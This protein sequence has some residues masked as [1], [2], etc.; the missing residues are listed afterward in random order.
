LPNGT[1]WSL[2]LDRGDELQLYALDAEGTIKPL[3]VRD[4]KVTVGQTEG[5]L[6]A[7][8]SGAPRRIGILYHDWSPDGQWLWYATLKPSS[9]PANVAIDDAVVSQRNRR[10]APVRAIVELR[11]RSATGEDWLVA[12]RPSGDRLAFY[13]GGHVEW[14]DEGPRYQLEQ[15][16]AERADG[17]G[18]FSW[19][20]VTNA[21]RPIQ[22]SSG[23]PA[24]WC[25]ARMAEL[26][27]A[28]VSAG[29]LPSRRRTPM[30]EKL[31]M[32][33][34]PITSATRV[35]QEIGSRGMG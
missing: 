9:E 29:R 23:F 8:R 2:L 5:A 14:T 4:A 12:S 19:S 1:G 17:I 7:V 28:R 13:Y 21:S 35:R 25:A 15:S 27:Q 22:E 34:S 30:A 31:T 3:L 33:A 11:I 6:F 10:R 18:T 32:V 24:I 20:F 26:L 16:D